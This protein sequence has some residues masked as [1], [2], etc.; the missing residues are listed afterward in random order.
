MYKVWIF[1]SIQR[2]KSPVSMTNNKMID[3]SSSN[4]RKTTKIAITTTITPTIITTITTTNFKSCN[5]RTADF[6][7]DKKTKTK[8]KE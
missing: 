1:Q 3:F 5:T 4:R 8:K 6:P 2:S 7:L